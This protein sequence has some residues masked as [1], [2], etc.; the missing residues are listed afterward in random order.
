MVRTRSA[1]EHGVI[2]KFLVLTGI[3]AAID[4]LTKAIATGYLADGVIKE[5]AGT[6][7][8]MLIYNTGATGGGSLGPYTMW[9]NVAVTV[10]AILLI[11]RIVAPLAA[12]DT[13]T[14]P[15]L[16]LVTGG[17]I[18][19]LA[20]MVLGPSGVADFLAVDITSTTTIVMNIADLFLWTGAVL[21]IPIV[22]R[23]VR[24]VLTE[25]APR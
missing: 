18:G 15:A 12:I 14:V 21:L 1:I 25:R 16:A 2:A 23:L 20:S 19:N 6:F 22:A 8:L 11:A 3:Y 10:I 24:A 5:L 13:R 17:A 7:S 9:I 4:L